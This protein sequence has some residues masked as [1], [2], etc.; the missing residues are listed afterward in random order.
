MNRKTGM[1]RVFTSPGMDVVTVSRSS[2]RTEP[3]GTASR[4]FLERAGAERVFSWVE[5][6]LPVCTHTLMPAPVFIVKR[7]S[8]RPQSEEALR[9]S[10]GSGRQ[11]QYCLCDLAIRLFQRSHRFLSRRIG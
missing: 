10:E 6:S 2:I 11:S 4:T 1:N 9:G 7:N 3:N 8:T 5:S